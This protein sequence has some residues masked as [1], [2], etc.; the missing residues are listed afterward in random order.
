[1]ADVRDCRR[2]KRERAHSDTY[3]GERATHEGS[4]DGAFP[5]RAGSHEVTSFVSSRQERS[6]GSLMRVQLVDDSVATTASDQ[7][8]VHRERSDEGDD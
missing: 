1:M 2:S 5:A 3:V 6:R 7:P 4:L 8:A